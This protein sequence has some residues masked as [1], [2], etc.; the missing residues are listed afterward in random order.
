VALPDLDRAD[1]F[2]ARFGAADSEGNE[3]PRTEYAAALAE[4]LASNNAD[5]LKTDWDT[6]LVALMV[7]WCRRRIANAPARP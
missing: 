4:V 6:H 2:L 3:Y 1:A 7:L 5:D